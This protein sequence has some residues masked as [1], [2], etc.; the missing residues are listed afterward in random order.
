MKRRSGMSR[1]E[2]IEWA[3]SRCTRD[4]NGCLLWP[5]STTGGYA[6]LGVGPDKSF[7]LTRL[8]LGLERGDPREALHSCDNTRCIAPEHLRVGTHAENQAEMSARGRSR[9]GHSSD[10]SFRNAQ[11]THCV[12]GHAFDE[13]NTYVE[14]TSAG[15]RRRQ[16]RACRAD[17][18]RQRRIGAPLALFLALA[19]SG[20]ERPE[21][22]VVDACLQRQIFTE[23]LAHLPTGPT[24]P[25]FND[26]DD[27]VDSCRAAA[28][29]Q[30]VRVCSVV[31]IECQGSGPGCPRPAEVAR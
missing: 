25:A 27:V 7:P 22:W 15:L 3:L 16:C 21:T 11:K 18:Q 24:A 8:L 5:G 30:S 29:D 2:L 4:E 9:G 28:R 10:G 17:Y 23:C 31:K 1:G 12:R 13:G 14:T 19:L 26:W 20:C 6:R